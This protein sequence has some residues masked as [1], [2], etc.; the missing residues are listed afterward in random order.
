VLVRRGL[1]ATLIAVVAVSVGEAAGWHGVD[2]AAAV[3]R[4]DSYSANGF[5]LWDFAWYGGHWTL[6]YSVIYPPIAATVGIAAT[7]IVSAGIAAW[8]FDGLVGRHLSTGGSA[9]SY[10]FALGTL[11]Q[12][13]IGQ[14]PFLTGEAFGLAA[15]L[16]LTRR[17][18]LLAV[19]LVLACTLTSPLPGAFA[20]LCAAAWLAGPLVG[21]PGRDGL[22]AFRR[23]LLPAAAVTAVAV[24]PI[25][26]GVLV[27]PGDGPMPYPVVDWLWE[28]AI[29]AVVGL[30]AGRRY[31]AVSAG[32]GMWALVAT[33]SV[34]IPSALG[35]NVGRIE[36][37]AALPLAVGLAWD[38]PRRAGRVLAAAAALPF[39]A[40]EWLPAAGAVFTAP[41]LASTHRYF[42]EPL[43]R[44]LA[45]LARTGP[46]GRVEVVPTE[47]HWEAAWVAPVMALARGWERQLDTAYNPIFYHPGLLN[48]RTYRRWLLANGVRYVALPRAPLDFAGTAEASL[49]SSGTVQG[50]VAT[51]AS[52]DWTLYEVKG[53]VGVVS[54]PA[55]LLRAA[56]TSITVDV[57]AR[58]AVTLRF[59]FSPDWDVTAG[60][61]CVSE[62]PG[63]WIKLVGAEKGTVTL[64]LAVSNP[65]A[66][67]CRRP[68]KT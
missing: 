10:L 13:A 45:A 49:V 40:S 50:L 23:R 28:M 42:Y 15:V 51:W 41:G 53:S 21:S 58:S 52:P 33:A 31:P 59:R 7:A 29:A 8:S 5:Q 48:A 46:P 22:A 66:S 43:D 63:S 2:T 9:A 38:Q 12:S 44:E 25:L 65:G 19:A 17:R 6:G 20:A 61:G 54:G 35:G 32:A 39:A 27:F 3:Y 37:V 18:H 14:L 36:D 11:V 68:V 67:A 16:A 64:S 30:L 34:A 24:T 47:Y 1:L 57:T 60:S 26:A 55:R 4:V 56:A 62:A